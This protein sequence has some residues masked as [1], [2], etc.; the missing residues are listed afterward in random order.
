MCRRGGMFQFLSCFPLK[1]GQGMAHLGH[2]RL[3]FCF[4][5]HTSSPYR[6]GSYSKPSSL[7]AVLYFPG[8]RL[9]KYTVIGMKLF[10]QIKHSHRHP[11][12]LIKT[13]LYAVNNYIYI[14][15]GFVEFIGVN[16]YQ[17]TNLTPSWSIDSKASGGPVYTVNN[18]CFKI[19]FFFFFFF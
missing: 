1:V 12:Q 15:C 16:R 9:Y 14:S 8:K 19:Q 11:W 6:P 3:L 2:F 18:I 17:K 5:L 10:V 13:S 4:V 7:K